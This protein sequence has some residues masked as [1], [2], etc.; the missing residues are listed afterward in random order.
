MLSGDDALFSW[1]SFNLIG[2]LIGWIGQLVTGLDQAIITMKK[3][4][5]SLFTLPPELSYGGTGTNCVPPNCGIR[6][7]VELIS[8]ITVIDV[9]KDGGIIKKVMD[10][11]E[12]IGPPSDLDEV[13]VKY[14]VR[15]NDGA[16]VATT[17]EGGVEFHVKD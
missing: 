2:L 4:E 1:D 11:G 8:W 16:I 7:E 3:G 12:Q 10:K 15:L 6:F 9:C 5:I 14:Q 13:L 17:P